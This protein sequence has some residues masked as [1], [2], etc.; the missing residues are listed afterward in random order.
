[1]NDLWL[2]C[3]ECT[4]LTLLFFFECDHNEFI[5]RVYSI[6]ISLP[7]K[8]LIFFNKIHENYS[9]Y[10]FYWHLLWTYFTSHRL[11]FLNHLS[12]HESWAF[13]YG[14]N[15]IKVQVSSTIC[16]TIA[17]ISFKWNSVSA[18][19]KNSKNSENFNELKIHFIQSWLAIWMNISESTFN[20][21]TY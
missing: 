2:D 21:Y 12:V 8:M 14:I 18:Q 6:L 10:K 1:M 17:E 3:I 15:W 7:S 11:N 13:N 16:R 5:D 4:I 19:Y 20:K 9:N